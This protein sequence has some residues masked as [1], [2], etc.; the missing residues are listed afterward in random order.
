MARFA[1]MDG[2]LLRYGSGSCHVAFTSGTHPRHV[3]MVGGLTDGMW[4]TQYVKPLA[5]A[6]ERCGW[7]FTQ[8][9]LSSSHHGYG[10][11]SLERDAEELAMLLRHL[12]KVKCANE[13]VVVGHSTGCQDAV[14]LAASATGDGRPD[15]LVLQA[16][17]SDRE[18][19]QQRVDAEKWIQM[20]RE[21]VERGEEE[22]ILPRGADACGA[23]ITAK[24]F[25]SLHDL[26]GDD[27]MFSSDLTDEE[28][29]KR[30]GHLDGV[31]TLMVLS[32][33]DEYVKP[34]LNALEHGSR[35]ATAAGT[36]TR[37]EVIEG[38]NH[39]LGDHTRN[40][41]DVV[42]QWLSWHFP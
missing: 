21:M 24:R 3:V 28:L 20:A 25:L 38:G 30:L 31:P 7:S 26:G 5:A 16:P 27:D 18:C 33:Q 4:A 12:R 41:V 17:V 2:T 35:L 29:E 13:V 10:T 37:L 40:L 9:L 22:E 11:S 15:G 14:R 32:E 19:Y 6:V 36:K 39:A 34:G 23:P 1:T 42:L 8:T